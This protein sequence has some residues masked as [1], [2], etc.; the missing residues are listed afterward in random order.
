[1]RRL[2]D[3]IRMVNCRVYAALLVLC[4]R[5]ANPAYAGSVDTEKIKA[6]FASVRGRLVVNAKE[7][8]HLQRAYVEWIDACLHRGESIERLNEALK[9]AG[10]VAIHSEVPSPDPDNDVGLVDRLV[11]RHVRADPSLAVVVARIYQNANC[12]GADT[13]IF[14]ASGFK[15]RVATIDFGVKPDFGAMYLSGLDAVWDATNGDLIV[16]SGWVASNCTSTWNGKQIQ[17]DRVRSASVRCLLRRSLYAH[18]RNDGYN[19]GATL[20]NGVASF[21]Y[22]AGLINGD[23]LAV[24]GV[25]SYR[26]QRERAVRVRPV[27][28]TR[29]G[30]IQEWVDSE[31]GEASDWSATEAAQVH[32]RVAR[33]LRGK[34]YDWAGIRNCGGEPAVWEVGTKTEGSS[35]VNVFRISGSRAQELRML[36]VGHQFE[37]SCKPIDEDDLTSIAEELAH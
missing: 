22:D 36:A 20:A 37:A 5:F 10:L 14:Y 2:Y 24:A 1:M 9:A 18:D 11:V 7:F 17:I 28:L 23:L 33:D 34:A 19:V 31:S 3:L 29:A 6:E 21:W 13:A 27:A 15:E 8:S 12:G 26:V 35:T 30:F 16:A 25:A 32:E 4:A